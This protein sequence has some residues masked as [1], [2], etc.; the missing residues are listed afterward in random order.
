[1]GNQVGK[2]ANRLAIAAISNV[3]HVEKRE[4][5]ALLSKFKEVASRENSLSMISRTDFTEA[6]NAVGINQN[7]ADILNHLFTMYDKS[8]DDQINYKEYIVGIAPLISGTH[9]EKIDFA[10]RLFDTEGTSYLKAKEMINVLSQ[11]NRVASYFGDPVMT[12]EQVA[13]VITDIQE[14]SGGS[15]DGLNDAIHY[16]EYIKIIAD[17][18]VVNTF[19][20]GGGTVQYGMG[21]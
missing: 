18:P 11:M 5:A 17:H 16:V 3:T 10:F 1:M 6:L 9:V 7:D 19:I 20:S 2:G 12:E 13:S 8:G 4:I 15:I 14:M 21:R